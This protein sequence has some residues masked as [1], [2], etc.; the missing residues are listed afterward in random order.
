MPDAP[1]FAFRPNGE[2]GIL[3]IPITTM[4]RKGQNIPCGGGGYF[5][6]F[7]YALFRRNL[8]KVHADDNDP[9][10]IFYFHP[11]E[12]DPGQPKIG[13]VSLKTRV[14]HYLNLSRM[15]RRL[16]RL[17]GDF[18]WGRMDEAFATEIEDRKAAT[19]A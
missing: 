13:G 3:E 15:E 14:R 8:T 17:L 12:V 9:S 18:R 6:L 10:A 2:N 16:R 7:P 11:W 19:A 1:R 5:R 4:V